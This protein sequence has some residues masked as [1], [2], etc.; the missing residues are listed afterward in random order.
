M[1]PFH[2]APSSL[3]NFSGTI[4]YNIS[5]TRLFCNVHVLPKRRHGFGVWSIFAFIIRHLLGSCSFENKRMRLLTR[6]YGECV[7]VLGKGNHN[8]P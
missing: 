4:M 3:A 2:P 7:E 8:G 5:T 6:A 1:S